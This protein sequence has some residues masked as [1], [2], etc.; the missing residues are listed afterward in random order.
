VG[1]FGA[2]SPEGNASQTHSNDLAAQLR[3]FGPV[4]LLALLL[5]LAGNLLAVP[6][7]AVLVLGWA[8]LS[9]TPWRT[10]G[11]AAPRNWSRTLAIGIPLGIAFKLAMKAIVMP[12]FGAPTVNLPYHYVAGNA[13]ALPWILFAVV[14]GGGFGE[15]T[16]FRGFLFERLGKLLGTQPA[17]LAAT[18]L[19]TSGLF[20]LAHYHDQGLPGVEQAAVTGAMFGTIYARTKQLWLPMVAHAAFDVAAVALIYWN[21]E[22][23]VAHLLFP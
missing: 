18:V 10:L 8:Q 23:A 16:V 12:L 9:H 20:A 21:W 22:S 13:A 2:P 3:R 15:E 11:F 19:L 7:S 5:I 4:G 14:V 1:H 6:L 17:A